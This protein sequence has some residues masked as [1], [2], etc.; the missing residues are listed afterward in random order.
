MLSWLGRLVLAST[1]LGP[2]ALVYSWAAFV[3]K[4]YWVAGG[5]L[6][7]APLLLGLCVI[8]I[9]NA[10]KSF[11]RSTI[12]PNAAEATDRESVGL[13][14]LYL[15]PL[16]TDSFTTLQ[17]AVI[18][19]TMIALGVIV[20]TG[21]NFY[22]SPLLGLLGWHSYRITDQA[23]ITYVVITKRQLRSS[24]QT[25]EV[26]QLTEYLLLDVKRR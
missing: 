12:N 17:W 14:V 5:L 26:V 18:I 21:Y 4:Q 11:E 10:Q 22:F 8:L 6:V 13:L 19:P 1:A 9:S 25:F 23:G 24:L 20:S 15:V 3:Q 7:S 2:I 16:F